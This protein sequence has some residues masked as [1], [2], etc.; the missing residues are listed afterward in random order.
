MYHLISFNAKHRSNITET[1][2]FHFGKKWGMNKKEAGMI[3]AL[4]METV[5]DGIGSKSESKAHSRDTKK[6]FVK[7]GNQTDG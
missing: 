2:L 6:E 4:C 5:V 7:N 3:L 1:D